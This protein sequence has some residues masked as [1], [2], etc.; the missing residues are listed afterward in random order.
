MDQPRNSMDLFHGSHD[1]YSNE[2]YCGLLGSWFVARRALHL[3]K[4]LFANA[5]QHELVKQGPETQRIHLECVHVCVLPK[6][7]VFR[8]H[9]D[10]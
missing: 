9:T 7:A 2:F 3:H 6:H 10:E 4:Q 1:P 5:P 8:D